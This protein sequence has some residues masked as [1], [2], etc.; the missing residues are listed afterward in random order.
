MFCTDHAIRIRIR[1][2]SGRVNAVD[3]LTGTQTDGCTNFRRS[4]LLVGMV[5]TEVIQSQKG[6]WS[7][8][9]AVRFDL[10]MWCGGYSYYL[11]TDGV[12]LPLFCRFAGG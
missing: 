11:R 7:R 6:F 5:A 9:Y 8:V 10:P 3:A 2:A 12:Q 4:S 1:I